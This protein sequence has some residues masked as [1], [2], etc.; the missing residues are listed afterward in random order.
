MANLLFENG[1]KKKRFLLFIGGRVVEKGGI[2]MTWYVRKQN[3]TK[4][5]KLTHAHCYNRVGCG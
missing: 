4:K 2:Q 3:K 5:A 1:K